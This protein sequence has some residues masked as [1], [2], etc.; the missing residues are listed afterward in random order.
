MDLSADLTK[1]TWTQDF[2]AIRVAPISG[3]IKGLTAGTVVSFAVMS[4]SGAGTALSATVDAKG[5][6][7][8]P[9]IVPGVYILTPSTAGKTFT[10]AHVAV[11][12]TD[13]TSSIKLNFTAK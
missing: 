12:I 13:T 3:T 2:S 9:N 6:Y 10:P 8:I 5:N 1:T 7:S 4:F 11:T